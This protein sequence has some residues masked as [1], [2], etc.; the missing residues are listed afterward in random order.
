MGGMVDNGMVE[1]RGG[2]KDEPDGHGAI[3]AQAA[4]ALRHVT[5]PPQPLTCSICSTSLH[6]QSEEDDDVKAKIW[7]L[8]ESQSLNLKV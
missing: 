4:R 7:H 5:H 1:S 6:A 3:L 8:A 2:L